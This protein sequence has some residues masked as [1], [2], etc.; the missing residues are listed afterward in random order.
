[1]LYSNSRTEFDAGALPAY[2][3]TKNRLLNYNAYIHVIAATELEST[4]RMMNH[5]DWSQANGWD[6]NTYSAGID[7]LKHASNR[8]TGATA[9]TRLGNWLLGA[10]T[11]G[12][13]VRSSV[14]YDHAS[15]RT[16]AV[17]GGWSQ[18]F[19]IH[20]RT[21]NVRHDQSSQF[22][23]FN[24]GNLGYNVEV[25]KDFHAYANV[26]RAYH[27]PTAGDLYPGILLVFTQP[28]PEAGAGTYLGNRSESTH[29][30]WKFN[31]AFSRIMCAI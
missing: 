22:R 8:S 26:G 27:A 1:M 23:G 4:I 12:A 28:Q 7:R 14:Q 30:N 20:G 13:P 19:G 15:R 25:I 18:K 10:E 17:F 16:N 3:E 24:S 5:R 31:A 11:L 29:R 9:S 21:A 2:P 6:W